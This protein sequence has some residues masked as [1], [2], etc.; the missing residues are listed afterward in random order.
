MTTALGGATL[1]RPALTRL[2]D[3]VR[4]REVDAVVIHRMDRLA[5]SLLGSAT[6]LEELRRHSVRLVIVTAPEPGYGAEDNFMLNIL[7]SFAEFE[8]DMIASRIAESRTR[9]RA[10]GRRLGGAVPFGYVTDIHTKQLVLLEAAAEIV[11]WMFAQ[12]AAGQVPAKIAEEANGNG[13]RTKVKFERRTTKTFGGNLWTSRL[14]LATLHSPVYTGMFPEGKGA[15]AGCHEPIIGRELFET[16]GL[17]LDSRKTRVAGKVSYGNVW[18]LKGL[19]RCAICERS[20]T[21][22]TVR[23]GNKVYRYYRCRSTAG[24]WKP[25]GGQ[26]AAG[27]IED[28]ICRQIPLPKPVRWHKYIEPEAI[29]EFIHKLSYDHRTETITMS[30]TPPVEAAT[31]ATAEP[32]V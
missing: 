18:P 29:P 23:H 21:P 11:K 27:P 22:H 24:G 4:K 17:Q 3:L 6:L 19:P 10:R 8:R 30:F 32:E 16:V 15:R 5:R 14:V 12:A 2:R 20:M 28:A 9:L 26:V 7:A 1:D 31:D 13:W 25:C